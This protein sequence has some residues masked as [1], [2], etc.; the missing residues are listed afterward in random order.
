[1][2]NLSLYNVLITGIIWPLSITLI[3]P[4]K[5]QEASVRQVIRIGEATQYYHGAVQDLD[6]LHGSWQGEGLGG[7]CREVWEKPFGN[8][9]MGMFKLIKDGKTV[10]YEFFVL[11]EEDGLI[12]LRLKHFTPGFRGWETKDK[13]VT[14]KLVEVKGHK[15]SFEGLTMEK[16]GDHHLRVYV[17]IKQLDGAVRE[18]FFEFKKQS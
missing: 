6:W 1:M 13:F 11:V 10:F 17:A 8:T 15:A 4:L 5:A 18:E 3:S 2:K 7:I 14:F 16:V 9:M 12:E